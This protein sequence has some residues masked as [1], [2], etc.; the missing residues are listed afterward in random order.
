MSTAYHPQTDRSS[1]RTNQTLEQYLRVFCGTQQN[2]W[3]A[4][5][6]L[7]Q[8]TKNS[9]PSATTKKTPFDLLI[10]YT[11]Q[12]HQPTRSS[13]LPTIEQRLSAIKEV[14]NATQEAQRKA[15]ESWIKECPQSTPFE[16]G[17][18]VWLEGTNPRLPSNITTKLAPRWYRPFVVAAKI[19]NITYN[20]SLLPTWKIHDIFHASLLT[21]YKETNQHGPNFIEPPPDI[22]EG[23]EEWEVKQIIKER[24]YGRWKKKQYL[25]RWR[26]Y[27]PVY[28]SWVN[29]EDL[30]TPELLADFQAIPSIKTLALDNTSSSC[31]TNQTTANPSYPTTSSTPSSE[32]QTFTPTPTNSTNLYQTKDQETKRQD[33]QSSALGFTPHLHIHWSTPTFAE[34]T[35]A[36]T[37][38]ECY[39]PHV[40]SPPA[41][42]PM[43]NNLTISLLTCVYQSNNTISHCS[44]LIRA[45]A[46]GPTFINTHC[47]IKRD[48]IH[49]RTVTSTRKHQQ[50][51]TDITIPN[52]YPLEH[53]SSAFPGHPSGNN[54]LANGDS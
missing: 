10:G 29:E 51:P 15:Q 1:E 32:T 33:F 8:Y 38:A 35:A 7:A 3:H 37:T 50:P 52:P 41:L 18:K 21:P 39:Q 24:T 11:P 28:N 27:S 17:T 44:T 42:S 31:P 46:N 43:L 34:T 23:E 40:Y 26:G 6:P 4:W 14:R 19:S 13:D 54:A 48:F 5:L 30:C 20:L 2:N 16:V 45:R 12:I 49:I 22:I 53:I 36:S 25:V 47:A 9:W